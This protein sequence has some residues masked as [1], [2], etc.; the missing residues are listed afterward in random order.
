MEKKFDEFSMREAQRLAKTDAGKQLM[1]LFQ[2][3]HGHKIPGK[4]TD[5]EELKRSLATF[6]RD[7]K[8]QA[9]LQQIQE[10]SHGRNG[11]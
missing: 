7:P 6:M 3:Q 10:E 9:L 5:M 8:A 2:Q 4:D 1:A 11:R